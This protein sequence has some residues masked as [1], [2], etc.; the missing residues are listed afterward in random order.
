MRVFF[1]SI[2]MSRMAARIS[3]LMPSVATLFGCANC[4]VSEGQRACGLA[5]ADAEA[6]AMRTPGVAAN[7]PRPHESWQASW[8]GSNFSNRINPRR[9]TSS[10]GK[11]AQE[12]C[13]GVDKRM[14]YKWRSSSPACGNK[15]S[16]SRTC[17]ECADAFINASRSKAWSS[18]TND[19]TSHCTTDFHCCA[20]KIMLR[21][22][23]V[24]RPATSGPPGNKRVMAKRPPGSG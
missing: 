12:L 8:A 20:V 24:S 2:A 15:S 7:R 14:S 17:T 19:S 5:G 18:A 1:G 9:F 23:T 6:V 10:S 13:R 3:K 11:S 16:L 22:S 4:P 21:R